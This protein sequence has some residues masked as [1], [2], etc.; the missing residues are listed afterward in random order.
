MK[1]DGFIFE[2]PGRHHLHLLLPFTIVFAVAVHIGLFFAF[3]ILYPRSENAGPNPAQIFFIPPGTPEAERLEG[4]LSF[5]DSAVFAPGR[6]LDLPDPVPPTTYLPGFAFDRSAL[7]GLP[8]APER[9]ALA[10]PAG[11]VRRF[12]PTLATSVPAPVPTKVLATDALEARVP[13]LPESTIFPV[14][15]GFDPRPPVFLTA[16]GEDG[17]VR[18]LFLQQGSGNAALDAKATSLLRGLVFAPSTGDEAWGF[19][20]FQWGTDIQPLATP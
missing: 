15:E 2:W 9:P 4:I 20:T 6:G 10:F 8:A 1:A 18:H 16:V 19:V 11:P 12:K 5:A 7:A 14:P 13:P 17:R 3:S